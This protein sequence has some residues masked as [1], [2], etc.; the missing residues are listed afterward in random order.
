MDVVERYLLN[1]RRYRPTGRADDLVAEL[2]EEHDL[3][4]KNYMDE[5]GILNAATHER[6]ELLKALLGRKAIPI[7][8]FLNTAP[9]GTFGSPTLSGK[10]WP[11]KEKE[12]SEDTGEAVVAVE[13]AADI[14]AGARDVD[15]IVTSESV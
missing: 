10:K 4:F 12:A 9:A 1:V 2:G 11:E 5:E 13:A 7:P 6:R 8:S 15:Q 14:P 3:K